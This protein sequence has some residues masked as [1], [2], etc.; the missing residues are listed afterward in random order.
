MGDKIY[1]TKLWVYGDSFAD[2]NKAGQ[3]PVHTG[4]ARIL[5]EKLGIPLNN[6]AISGSST[7]YAI[8]SF[9]EDV[10]KNYIGNNDIV[11]VVTSSLGR[12]HFSYQL[13]EHPASAS[14]YL[15]QSPPHFNQDWYQKNKNHIEW[16]MINN[17]HTMQSITFESYAQLLKNFANSKPNCTVVLLPAFDYGYNKDIFNDISPK[18]FL[19]SKTYLTEISKSETEMKNK[20]YFN[21][22]YWCEYIKIDPR[23]NHLTNP[24]LTILANLLDESIQNLAIDNITYDKF[25]SNNVERI[26]SREQYIKYTSSGVLTHR[27]DL[28][29]NLK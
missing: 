22:D 1:M 13:N 29:N 20:E 24:N 17:N 5:S 23:N 3:P 9:I 19:R 28:E 16:W 12:L 27:Y 10:N 25:Q 11:I 6:R 4:W 15:K 26:T 7:E 21:Y 18:N 8:K 14:V 2:T